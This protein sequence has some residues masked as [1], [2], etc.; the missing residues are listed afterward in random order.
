MTTEQE[1]L[2]LK[3][4]VGDLET[5]I[6]GFIHQY[7]VDMA[8]LYNKGGYVSGHPL[9]KESVVSNIYN[10]ADKSGKVQ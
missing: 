7:G 10:A 5:L 1:I 4:Q 8:F 2:S 9:E 6:S 3:N